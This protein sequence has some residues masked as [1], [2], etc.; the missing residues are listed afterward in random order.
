MADAQSL[1]RR[2]FK[3]HIS[4]LKNTSFDKENSIYLCNDESIDIYD[5]D[6]IVKKLYPLKQLSSYDALLIDNNQIF[7]VA[8][9]N[10]SARWRRAIEKNTIQFGLEEFKRTYFNE[11]Y[12]N[13]IYFFTSEYKKYFKN[14]LVC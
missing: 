12:T 9:K 2:N 5:F 6:Y 3:A 14:S 8:Y 7:C 13:D 1:F 11:I 4:S 10:T